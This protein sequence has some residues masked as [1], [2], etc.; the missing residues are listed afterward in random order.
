M[1]QVSVAACDTFRSGAVE[2]LRTHSKNLGLR[3]FDQGYGKDAAG[4]AQRAIMESKKLG[5]P[6]L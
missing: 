5:M 1:L 4:V 3:L 2:Q 6:C